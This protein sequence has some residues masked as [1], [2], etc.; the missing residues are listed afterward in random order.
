MKKI[1]PVLLSLY[2]LTILIA[3]LLSPEYY[4]VVRNTLSELAAQKFPHAWLMR[5]GFFIFAGGIFSLGVLKVNTRKLDFWQTAAL[6]CL[7]LYGGTILTTGI[8]SEKNFFILE[9][10]L[11]SFLHNFFVRFSSMFFLLTVWSNA[12][13]EKNRQFSMISVFVFFVF[14]LFSVLFNQFEEFQG[15]SQRAMHL[16]A[17]GWLFFLYKQ[18][19]QYPDNLAV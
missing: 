10:N 18:K 19:L 1:T 14:V 7:M 2:L 11:E 16:V 4:S 6:L 9:N 13:A 12:T 8:W 17:T 15:L 5:G 3:G